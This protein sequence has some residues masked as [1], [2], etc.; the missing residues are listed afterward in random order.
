MSPDH[1]REPSAYRGQRLVALRERGLDHPVGSGGKAERP[2]LTHT[3]HR[4]DYDGLGEA[5]EAVARCRMTN[6]HTPNGTRCEV[7]RDRE[8]DPVNMQTDV[9]WL[10]ER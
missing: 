2:V 10:L 7:Y 5:H 9:Y 4:G 3:I 6:G 8:E 1:D